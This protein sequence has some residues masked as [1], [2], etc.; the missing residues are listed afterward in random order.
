MIKIDIKVKVC[1][2]C[3]WIS[4]LAERKTCMHCRA[5]ILMPVSKKN[6]NLR[7]FIIGIDWAKD[8]GNNRGDVIQR[9][10]NITFVRFK[11]LK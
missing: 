7:S 10:D 2:N 8:S 5:G 3:G 1:I 9:K 6:N 4:L 11:T